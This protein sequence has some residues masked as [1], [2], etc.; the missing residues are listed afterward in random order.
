MDNKYVDSNEIE[1]LFNK[2]GYAIEWTDSDVLILKRGFEEIRL[3]A[4]YYDPDDYD[5][6]I[7]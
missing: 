1:E 6:Y 2:A 5:D 7:E 4:I 3:H